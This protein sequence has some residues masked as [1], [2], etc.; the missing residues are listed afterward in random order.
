MSS[1]RVSPRS[2]NY[3][4]HRRPETQPTLFTEPDLIPRQIENAICPFC[5]QGRVPITAEATFRLVDPETARN[6][7]LKHTASSSKFRSTSQQAD[8]LRV[9]ATRP[10]TAQEAALEV[11]GADAPISSVEAPRRRV[12]TLRHLG[13][14]AD[15]GQRRC[16]PGSTSPSAIWFVT[17]KGRETLIRLRETGWSE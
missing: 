9:I 12:S 11:L 8:I 17:Q 6:A 5:H 7:G 14:V 1:I 10:C 4:G 16:N 15:S 3:N 2:L 13:L